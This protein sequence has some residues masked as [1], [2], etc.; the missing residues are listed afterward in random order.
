MER[1]GRGFSREKYRGMRNNSRRNYPT[2][3]C[4]MDGAGSNQRRNKG[5]K[6]AEDY[7][8]MQTSP[9]LAWVPKIPKSQPFHKNDVHL[10]LLGETL[11]HPINLDARDQLRGAASRLEVEQV[12]TVL[13]EIRI[14]LRI[15]ENKTKY[16][17]IWSGGKDN[18]WKDLFP[19]VCRNEEE[20]AGL[21]ELLT[22]LTDKSIRDAV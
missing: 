5:K 15:F 18:V 17:K 9:R 20:L 2:L 7:A 21:L 22:K 11:N 8:E 10:E 1:K 12:A 13:S 4:R 6:P 3:S 14:L 19:R 16:C